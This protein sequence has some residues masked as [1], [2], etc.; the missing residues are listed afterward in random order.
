MPAFTTLEAFSTHTLLVPKDLCVSF[1]NT[2]NRFATDVA[3]NPLILLRW[4][5]PCVIRVVKLIIKLWKVPMIISNTVKAVGFAL[6]FS[7]TTSVQAMLI[8]GDFET[9]DLTGWTTFT[10][11][12]G[13]LGDGGTVASFD[14]TGSGASLAA[15]FN[16]GQQRFNPD[17]LAGGG[18]Y[19]SVVLKAGKYSLA[20]DVAALGSDNDNG[21]GGVFDLIFDGSVLSTFDSS[22]ILAGITERSVLGWTGIVAAG[23]HEVRILMQRPF[24]TGGGELEGRTPFQYIDN[25]VLKPVSSSKVPEPMSLA[26]FG[27]GLAGL[28]WSRRK[29]A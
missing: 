13:T 14:T 27:I 25:V 15:T 26:L 11:T 8:N 24:S 16:V 19:Q 28:G 10:T 4:H 18:I 9:G 21:A 22:R 5:T 3:A 12:N 1:L 20:L 6:L 7:C 23:S 17:V 2:L 29:K